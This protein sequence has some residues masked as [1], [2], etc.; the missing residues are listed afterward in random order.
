MA[1]NVELTNIKILPYLGRIMINID[2]DAPTVQA[3][4][5]K[6]RVSWARL[7]KVLRADNVSLQV[8]AMF[9]WAAAH[10]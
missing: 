2:D 10:H 9:Y 7:R 4:L 5:K 1:Y 8:S 6:A 3:R